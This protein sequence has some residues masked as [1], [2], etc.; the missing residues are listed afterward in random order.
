MVYY[1]GPNIYDVEPVTCLYAWHPKPSKTYI[2]VGTA[3]SKVLV[4]FIK[5]DNVFSLRCTESLP[6]ES[7]TLFP[8]VSFITGFMGG[9][10]QLPL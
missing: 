1:A 8:S 4:Y 6:R 5:R 2:C 7:N 3:S 10:W 9:L